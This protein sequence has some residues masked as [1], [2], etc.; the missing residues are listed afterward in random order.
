MASGERVSLFFSETPYQFVPLTLYAEADST[1][2]IYSDEYL[3]QPYH[4]GT[5]FVLTAYGLTSELMA[6]T[7]FTDSPKVGSVAAGTQTGIPCAGTSDQ[8]TYTVTVNRGTGSGSP[9]NFH[10]HAER[11][12]GVA[13][14]RFRIVLAESGAARLER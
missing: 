1:G 12:V 8:A 14:R 4:L 5:S 6:Q 2:A 9:G 10:R 11:D 3:V 7:A 13:F